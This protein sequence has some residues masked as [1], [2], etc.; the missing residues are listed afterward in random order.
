MNIVVVAPRLPFPLD[1]GDRLTVYHLLKYFS[2]RHQVSLVCFLESE[3]DSA[4]VDKVAPFCQRVEILPLRKSRAYLNC[5][6]GLLGRTPLQLQYYADPAMHQTV[7]RV[8][9]DMKP[10]LLYAQLIRM[11]QYIESYDSIARVAA[12]N[13]SMTL[14]HRRLAD[15]ASTL[16][17]KLL[18]SI[19]YRKLRAFESDFARRFDRVLYISQHDVTAAGPDMPL[20]KVFIN[21]HGVDCVYFAPDPTV[22]K[23]ANS[24][25]FTGNMS[26]T[27]NVDAALYFYQEIFPLVQARI[28]DVTLSIVGTDP[29]PE[30]RA[31]NQ[32]AAVH[33]T[34]RIPDLREYMNRSQVVVAPIRIGAGLQNKVLEGMSM[35]LPM[36]ATPV[37]NE[38]IQ[39]NDGNNILI[40]NDSRSFAES[41]LGL[42]D[43][44][45]R[46]TQLGGAA[47]NFIV[48]NWTWEAHFYNLEQMF[49]S[50]VNEK[51]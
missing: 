13:L 29:A 47:R 6:T 40:A 28:P 50:L 18:H 37:A 21:P 2:Q 3:Q 38:G 27:P 9:Q 32:D 35:G 24:L 10:N 23:R 26:Y 25:I 12:F 42:L 7:R 46:R 30:I 8:I 19:E 41:I 5:M 20:D 22:P 14:N 36:V 11:G 43:D 1:K 4:W 44:P 39:A 34:G 48:Q 17:G 51:E 15:H 33:V 31:L 49:V 45:D 16:S